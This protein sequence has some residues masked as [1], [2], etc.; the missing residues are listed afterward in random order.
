M[1]KDNSPTLLKYNIN[2]DPPNVHISGDNNPA[3]AKIIIQ[4]TADPNV[5]CKDISIE[6]PI[7]D[8]AT[9]MYVTSPLPTSSCNNSDW[10]PSNEFIPGMGG[11]SND[12]NDSTFLYKHTND[13]YAVDS[14]VTFTINGTVNDQAGIA[15]ITIREFSTTIDDGNYQIRPMTHNITKAGEDAFYL[16]S[17]VIVYIDTPDVPAG[18]LDR[19][20]GFQL[21]W[22]SNGTGF[23]LYIGG[24]GG[25][26]IDLGT[27]SYYKVSAGL[28]I[29]TTYIIQAQKGGDYLYLEYTASVNTPDASFTSISANKATDL[30][31]GSTKILSNQQILARSTQV[32]P[33]YWYATTDGFVIANIFPVTQSDL[34]LTNEITIATIVVNSISFTTSSIADS[35][36]LAYNSLSIPVRQGDSF[37]CFSSDSNAGPGM[38]AT[39]IWVGLGTGLPSPTV[40][41]ESDKQLVQKIKDDMKAIQHK[42]KQKAADFITAFESAFDRKLSGDVKEQ[43]IKKLL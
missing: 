11:D 34:L 17:A 8:G 22:Q 19:Y 32:D 24:T 14:D 10:V 23:K 5:L 31:Q 12:G 13:G 29:D 3:T 21:N 36:G 1:Q 28:A 25:Q 27:Q 42:R 18:L 38:T 37:S 39:F 2:T 4:V 9:D 43:L 41:S 16:N 40:G 30:S 20:R 7:G 35:I 15:Q 6:V 26:P 33:S